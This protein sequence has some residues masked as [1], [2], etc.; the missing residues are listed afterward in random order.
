MSFVAVPLYTPKT[1]GG[2]ILKMG[3]G[4]RTSED[5]E[6]KSKDQVATI[7]IYGAKPAGQTRPRLEALPTIY[8]GSPPCQPGTDW[9]GVRGDAW[10]AIAHI[11]RILHDAHVLGNLQELADLKFGHGAAWVA[12][13]DANPVL[14]AHVENWLVGLG[15]VTPPSEARRTR[16]AVVPV[17]VSA[18]A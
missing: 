15:V 16:S 17:S 3:G 12:M 6:T 4:V 2:G 8:A 11:A 1:Y 14:V 18:K 7:K 10:M 9:D 5:G 13:A